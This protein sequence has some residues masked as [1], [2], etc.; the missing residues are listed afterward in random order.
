MTDQALKAAIEQHA[1]QTVMDHYRLVEEYDVENVGTR[2][3]TTFGPR[4]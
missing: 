1:V 4:V 3:T 2:E